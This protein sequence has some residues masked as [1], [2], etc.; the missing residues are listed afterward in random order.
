MLLTN[1][2]KNIFCTTLRN[3]NVSTS[4][5]PFLHNYNHIRTKLL[6]K[7]LPSVIQCRN[8]Q[9]Q[10]LLDLPPL[11]DEQKLLWPGFINI[12]KNLVRYN[13]VIK[14][15][16][17]PEFNL[18]EFLEGSKQA[19]HVIS[20]ALAEENYE[21]IQELV[22]NEAINEIRGRISSLTA[23]QKQLIA[24]NK[25]DI[26]VIFPHLIGIMFDENRA[27]QKFVEITVVYHSLRGLRNELDRHDDIKMNI[28]NYPEY[29]QR[30]FVSNYRF[31]REFTKGVES[32]WTVNK[33]NHFMT[34]SAA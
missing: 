25:N 12:I 33:I 10:N 29:A 31:I 11:T 15:Y 19:L 24:V 8:Y 14:A 32:S 7:L 30:S 4:A 3:F 2:Y 28:Q 21:S 16:M 22:S 34:K 26:Y 1:C 6:N 5:K 27:E 23:E 13:F 17:E 20:H 9:A 18:S